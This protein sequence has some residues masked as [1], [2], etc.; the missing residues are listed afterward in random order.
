VLRELSIC[1]SWLLGKR[2]LTG[3]GFQRD[4]ENAADTRSRL[5]SYFQSFQKS[6]N[7]AGALALWTCAH[8]ERFDRRSPRRPH[9]RINVAQIGRDHIGAGAQLSSLVWSAEHFL[10]QI[11]CPADSAECKLPAPPRPNDGCSSELD[12]WFKESTLHPPPSKPKPVLTLAGLP[13]ACRQI[14]DVRLAC[15][16]LW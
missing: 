3:Q 6:L 5:L 10:V 7:R 13:P 1:R 4:R 8:R 11:A 14:V 15:G 9:A 2:S 16:L 12:F